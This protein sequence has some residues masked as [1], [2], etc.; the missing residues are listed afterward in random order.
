M[1]SV[2]KVS[3]Q[4][5][6]HL[7]LMK[8]P[9]WHKKKKVCI[10]IYRT[11]QCCPVYFFSALWRVYFLN[12][13]VGICSITCDGITTLRLPEEV[14]LHTTNRARIHTLTQCW[15]LA[16]CCSHMQFTI[17]VLQ[18]CTLPVWIYSRLP[19]KERERKWEGWG[20]GGGTRQSAIWVLLHWMQS[21]W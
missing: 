20:G 16:L 18:V 9:T 8:H 2:F 10:S 13:N 19:G 1:K 5:Q 12:H 14:C 11:V 7:R 6:K 17:W 15:V 4:G 3:P 21:P